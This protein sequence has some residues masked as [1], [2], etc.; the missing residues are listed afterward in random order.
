M[1]M[2]QVTRQG[3]VFYV[4][5]LSI[6]MIIPAVVT[7]DENPHASYEWRIGVPGFDGWTMIQGS[8]SCIWR[9]PAPTGCRVVFNATEDEVRADESVD[10]IRLA[11]EVALS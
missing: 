7:T 11:W 4:N 1:R 10:V 6:K 8:R 9:R 2:M 3:Q 5:P